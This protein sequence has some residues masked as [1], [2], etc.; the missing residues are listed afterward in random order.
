MIQTACDVCVLSGQGNPLPFAGPLVGLGDPLLYVVASHLTV[1]DKTAMRPL[2]D[3]AGTLLKQ[4]LGQE[5][6]YRVGY[7]S[8]C[9]NYQNGAGVIP[10]ELTLRNCSTSYLYKDIA[11]SRP[12]VILALGYEVYRFLTGKTEPIMRARG[13]FE[14]IE[15]EGRRIPVLP[16]MHPAFAL[17]HKYHQPTMMADLALA[18]QVA[19]E[20]RK[21]PSQLDQV[22]YRSKAENIVIKTFAEFESYVSEKVNGLVAYDLETTSFQYEPQLEITGFSLCSSEGSACYVVIKALDYE[23]PYFDRA[24]TL[25]L[26]RRVLLRSKVIVHNAAFEWPATYRILGIEIPV[27]QVWDT[28]G[29]AR[30][31]LAGQ[32]NSFSLK[33]LGSRVGETKWGEDV[34]GFINAINAIKAALEPTVSG[35]PRPER[36]FLDGTLGYQ[37]CSL[38]DLVQRISTYEK[39]VKTGIKAA[40]VGKNG[41]IRYVEETRSERHVDGRCQTIIKSIQEIAIQ[42]KKAGYYGDDFLDELEKIKAVILD[43]SV[44]ANTSHVPWR[45]ISEYGGKDA[46]VTYRLFHHLTKEMSANPTLIDGYRHFRKQIYFGFAMERVGIAFDADKRQ[47]IETE[48]NQ[49]IVDEYCKLVR[50]PY[51]K[52]FLVERKGMTND[53][54]EKAIFVAESTYTTYEEFKDLLN[55]GSSEQAQGFLEIV[56][57]R[58]LSSVKD[59]K[60]GKKEVEKQVDDNW[61]QAHFKEAYRPAEHDIWDEATWSDQLRALVSFRIIKKTTKL[62]TAYAFGFNRFI[63]EVPKSEIEQG[64][65]YFPTRL[66]KWNEAAWDRTAT[67][68]IVQA[69]FRV[70]AAETG[71]WK[72]S[73]PSVHTMPANSPAKDLFVSRF[74][75][76]VILAP[77]YSQNEV[78]VLAAVS[79]AKTLLD[80]FA[81]GLDPHLVTASLMYNI[82][83][84]QVTKEQRRFS[85]TG[86][87]AVLYGKGEQA[88]ADE[89]CGGDLTQAQK[90]FET[91]FGINPEIKQFVEDRHQDVEAGR[92]IQ[93]LT[94][95]QCFVSLGDGSRGQRNEAMRCGQNYPIQ[96]PSS[97][98]A[99]MAG[100]EVVQ[101]IKNAGL[102]SLAVCFVH[103]SL[104]Y[105]V[106]PHEIFEMVNLVNYRLN[107]YPMREWKVP[108]EA[109]ITI[110][111]TF[112]REC[113]ISK[114]Q[115]SAAG[116]RWTLKGRADH[117]DDLHQKMAL[118]YEIRMIELI[119]DTPREVPVSLLFEPKIAMSFD[120]GRRDLVDR[121][122]VFEYL[123]RTVR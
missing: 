113:G 18:R 58:S 89:L 32:V 59:G 57:N 74:E 88:V 12:E 8:R 64:K 83:I 123:P 30:V 33:E 28:M 116:W 53:E 107:E 13:T 49:K 27:D 78:R 61:V 81:K 45:V 85:K 63:Y 46:N 3:Q 110:G 34:W 106:H 52:R 62:L 82:P 23:M 120:L 37:S 117:I 9:L 42:L 47:S 72:S 16:V 35:K 111:T 94:K 102:R 84:D 114:I 86:T 112:G 24:K 99:G 73:E 19:A 76:G 36:Q 96:G 115:G 93:F 40:K 2:S 60:F 38:L 68:L 31:I 66:H 71:R 15:I 122:A 50:L 118:N 104:E 65:T 25:A 87:F 103:D 29:M 69:N 7:M 108:C 41:A 105:D 44:V 20:L 43:Y 17:N 109:E 56:M 70:G 67:E 14:V 26:L 11:A 119:K 4:F 91:Y 92:P 121:S 48:C 97:D 100:F 95:R 10:D 101:D 39:K 90:L 80:G 98:I 5:T 77:D 54:A 21:D 79:G 6:A 55:F 51:L 1:A 22:L 75:G